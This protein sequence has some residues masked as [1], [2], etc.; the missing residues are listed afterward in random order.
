MYRG[1]SGMMTFRITSIITSRNSLRT[2]RKALPLTEARARPSTKESIRADITPK[3]GGMSMT[4][5]GSSPSAAASASLE[6]QHLPGSA[7]KFRYTGG[8]ET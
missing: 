5:Y 6:S 8:H 1:S 4:K 3:R 2:I 7:S